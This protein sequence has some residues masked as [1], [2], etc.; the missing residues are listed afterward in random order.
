MNSLAENFVY[1]ASQALVIYGG[2]LL[3]ENMEQWKL[4]RRIL[5]PAFG[6]KTYAYVWKETARIY[7]DMIQTE[8]WATKPGNITTITSLN[9][10][11]YKLGLY[12]IS[13]C[14][15]GLTFPWSEPPTINGQSTI[16][17]NI[18]TVE[19]HHL[20]LVYAPKW[21]WKL[22]IKSCVI[23]YTLIFGDHR[24]IQIQFEE[25]DWRV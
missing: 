21:I 15:F 20:S 19:N 7:Q 8:N 6:T 13:I 4:H 25:C 3:S 22:P 1:R 18:E 5:Q 12:V 14:G 17:N 10:L 2:N 9:R 24:L 11:S 23:Q 16:Q